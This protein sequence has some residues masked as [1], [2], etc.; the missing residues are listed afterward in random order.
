VA[1][2]DRWRR[3]LPVTRQ[4]AQFPDRGGSPTTAPP[5]ST[6]FGAPADLTGNAERLADFRNRLA[7]DRRPRPKFTFKFGRCQ[8]PR[9]HRY[10]GRRRVKSPVPPRFAGK[11]VR[12]QCLRRSVHRAVD[13]T[14]GGNG[15]A[16]SRVTCRRGGCRRHPKVGSNGTGLQNRGTYSKSRDRRAFMTISPEDRVTAFVAGDPDSV[17]DMIS[18]S[19]GWV[20]GVPSATGPC[21]SPPDAAR[22]R[23]FRI[24]ARPGIRIPSCQRRALAV[25]ID[26]RER[27]L[28]PGRGAH[29]LR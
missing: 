28:P 16:D 11:S 15:Y 10:R 14:I 29:H 1:T 9:S 13:P 26:S 8:P 19:H 25:S 2:V 27:R 23:C 5:R 21:G 6:P 18:A 22:G 3:H 20:S 12:L 4:C 24:R 17:W 7:V